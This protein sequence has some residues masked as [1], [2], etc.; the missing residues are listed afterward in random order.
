MSL[1]RIKEL[2]QEILEK[3]KKKK[4]LAQTIKDAFGNY[5]EYKEMEEESK[6]LKERRK[7]IEA[8]VRQ[9]Y[10]SEF[11]DLEEINADIKDTKMVLS[12]L[13]WNEVMQNNSVEVVDEW[14]HHY[15][16]QIVASLKKDK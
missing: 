12:D 13:I 11:N 14:D 6:K 2:H 10:S 7:Q 4:D 15:V 3:Q 1:Q 9:Q 16:P 5:K 8:Q